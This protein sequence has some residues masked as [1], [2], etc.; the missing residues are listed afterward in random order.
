MKAK[1][2]REIPKRLVLRWWRKDAKDVDQYGKK[3]DDSTQRGFLVRHGALH[4]KSQWL[5]YL[6]SQDEKLFRKAMDGIVNLYNN[7]ESECWGLENE[8]D[9]KGTKGVVR[10]PKVAKPKG[11]LRLTKQRLLGKRRLG[12][13]SKDYPKDHGKLGRIPLT[14]RCSPT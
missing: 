10:D 6:G 3:W 1:H 13:F 4:T 12:S 5:V 11:A 7:L 9:T 8:V 14:S 2:L